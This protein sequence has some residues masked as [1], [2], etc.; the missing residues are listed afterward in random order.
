LK[1][2]TSKIFI[3]EKTNPWDNLAREEYWMKNA[4]EEDILFYLWQ[5]QHTIVIGRNQNPWKEISLEIFEEEG[6]KLARRLSGG[7]AVYHDLGN[8]NFTFISNRSL[9]DQEK[10]FTVI[11]K[12]LEQ[13]GLE[14]QK[15]GR[16]DLLIEGRKFSGNA[17]YYYGNK[18]L[19][20]GT[21]LVN[22]DLEKAARYL[23]PSKEKL[24]SKGITSV[25]SRIINLQEKK[26]DLTVSLLIPALIDSFKKIYASLPEVIQDSEF[27]S[28]IIEGLKNKYRSNEWRYGITPPFEYNESKRFDWGECEFL[29]HVK[30]GRLVRTTIFS[31]CLF[32]DFIELISERLMNIPFRVSSMVEKLNEIKDAE[33]I[34]MI[35]DLAEWLASLD[36]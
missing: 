17:F 19:H 15:G 1:P 22:A 34:S 12:A 2:L 7:G 27:D 16:N 6:G 14:V 9:Y 26:S 18:A 23:N 21:L 30:E 8:L 25:R 24:K 28:N 36:I 11:R 31:D 5:N 4:G 3:E 33:T 35:E 13:F 29:F 20:H 32:P 10:Q